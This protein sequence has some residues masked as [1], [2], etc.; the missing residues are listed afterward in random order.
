[1]DN[2][3]HYIV[4]HVS[5]NETVIGAECGRCHYKLSDPTDYHPVSFC[6]LVENK[7]DP[8][9]EV[10][11]ARVRIPEA[12]TGHVIR[13]SDIPRVAVRKVSGANG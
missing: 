10:N 6:V 11:K 4:L 13:Q 1:M 12:V 3:E 7:Y 8:I 5:P 2:R 9:E